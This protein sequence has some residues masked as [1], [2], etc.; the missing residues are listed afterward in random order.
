MKTT[1]RI[2]YRNTRRQKKRSFLLGGA[3]AFGVLVITLVNAFTYGMVGNIKNN[4]SYIFGGHIYIAG[5]EL[6]SSGRVVNTISNNAPVE[7]ALAEV[8][9]Y[10]KHVNRRSEAFAELIF[11]SK[12]TMQIIDGVDWT[13]ESNLAGKLAVVQGSL[14]DLSDPHALVLP[15]PVAD[16]LGVAVGETVLA[17]LSTATGQQNVGEFRLIAIIQDQTNFGFSAGYAHLAYVNELLSLKGDA[18]QSLNITLN[19][20]KDM[21]QVSDT[22]YRI[23]GEKAVV[24]PRVKFNMNMADDEDGNSE[25]AD[26]ERE[27]FARMF[28]GS[29]KNQDK[30]WKGTKFAVTTLNDIMEPVMSMVGVLNTVSLVVFLIL[31][32]ITMVG[33]MNTFRMIMI[34]RTQEIGTMRAF[35]M[36]R[37][38]VRNIFLA[39]ALFIGLGGALAGLLVAGIVMLVFSFITFNGSP[40]LQFFMDNGRLTFRLIPAQV[41]GNLVLLMLLTLI[42]AYMPAR[43]A[44]KLH[45]ADALRAQ[46]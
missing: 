1:L 13:A 46:Y 18:Y 36:Q 9:Q 23:L 2:A 25:H 14:D 41:L 31:L 6:T 30:P 28:G 44:A 32:V 8:K 39:E 3:I 26:Q 16:K 24:K 11:G 42:A 34:E 19:D 45:P 38:M 10:I 20:M 35:G 29:V 40:V 21:N 15:K 17:R 5:S 7:A 22:I 27:A 33:I 43:A 4:F 12:T 37:K